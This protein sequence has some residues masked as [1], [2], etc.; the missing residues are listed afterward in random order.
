MEIPEGIAERVAHMEG[1]ISAHFD[2]VE[3]DRKIRRENE[4]AIAKRLD[5]L[6]VILK[7]AKMSGK[8][9]LAAAMAVGGFISWIIGLYVNLK[10]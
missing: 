2:S 4:K 3:R 7:S 8:L 1:R 10:K 9:L 5:E 6:E